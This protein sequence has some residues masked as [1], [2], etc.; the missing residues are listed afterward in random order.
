MT[1][2]TNKKLR[3]NGFYKEYYIKN[4][5]EL[6]KRN[7]ERYFINKELKNISLSLN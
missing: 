3:E 5:E 4:R 7:K 2:R 1:D 6:L